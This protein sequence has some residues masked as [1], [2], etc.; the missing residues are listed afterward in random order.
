MWLGGVAE[1]AGTCGAPEVVD[2]ALRPLLGHAA[3]L[4]RRGAV[5]GIQRN[6]SQATWERI[7]QLAA[8][9]PVEEVRLA[10]REALEECG[11]EG[12]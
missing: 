8:E 1:A 11:P 5:W 3:P 7:R 12:G 6:A 2:A 10:A 4:V 9:D